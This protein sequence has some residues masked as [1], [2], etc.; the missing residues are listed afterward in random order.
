MKIEKLKELKERSTNVVA[1]YAHPREVRGPFGRWFTCDGGDNGM[2]DPVK[3]PT[4]V[5]PIEDDCAYAAAAMNAVPSLI[6]QIELMEWALNEI[7]KT[8]RRLLKSS[9]ESNIA[10]YVLELIETERYRND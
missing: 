2:G 4:P 8:N 10:L 5:A 6:K 1:W 9:A 3:Y 7:V